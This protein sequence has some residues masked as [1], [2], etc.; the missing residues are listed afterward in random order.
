[1]KIKILKAASLDLIEGFH[2]YEKQAEGIGD[3]FLDSLFGDID[4]L[5]ENAGIHSVYFD[6]YRR[7]LASRFPF[8]IY[9]RVDRDLAL[10]VKSRQRWCA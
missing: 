7:L 4:S 1:M 2:F 3:D 5:I 9:Y 6:R 8:A 10:V